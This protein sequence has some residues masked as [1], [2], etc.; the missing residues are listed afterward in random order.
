MPLTSP[1]SL[2]RAA[3]FLFAFAKGHTHT[4][5]S[6]GGYGPASEEEQTH[7]W[8]GGWEAGHPGGFR[9]RV[10]FCCV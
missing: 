7:T 8:T 1:L 4:T 3:G 2:N 6:S 5:H 9:K 10:W